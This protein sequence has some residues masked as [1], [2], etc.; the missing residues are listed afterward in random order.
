MKVST[1][2]SPIVKTCRKEW[3]KTDGSWLVALSGGADSTALLLACVLGA[4]PVEAAHCNFNLR[5]EESKRDEQFV[6]DLCERLGVRLHVIG[7]DTRSEAKPGESLEM[8]CRRLRYDFF[9]RLNGEKRF[10]R[11]A[12]AH[13]ADDNIET[14]FLNALRGSASR[15]L[16]AMLTDTG[17]LIR[18]LL[19]FH[20]TELLE[21]LDLNNQDFIVDSSNLT[22]D[23]RRNFLRNEIFP[24]LATR[25]PGF[26]KAVTS[27][28]NY[29]NKDSRIVDYYISAALSE[30]EK[31]LSWE[32]ID[33]FPE[34][35]TLI[36]RFI[37]PYGGSST[38]AEEIAH[39]V[40]NASRTPGKRWSLGRT[41]SARLTR[42]GIQIVE[43]VSDADSEFLNKLS[44]YKWEELSESEI[45]KEEIVTAPLS[46]FFSPYG[47]E[48]YEWRK[49]DRTQRIKSL[50]LQ[51]SQSVWKVLKDAG[52]SAEE[53]DAFPVLTDKKTGEPVWLP[54]VKRS[55]LH[56][57]DFTSSRIYRLS[58]Y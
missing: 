43:N 5:G 2:D 24:M 22:S 32:T 9:E 53:R 17:L 19:A 31:F 33:S 13:N 18:P 47:E 7:F 6:R 51:G 16:K 50:G 56:L 58:T 39:S 57:V 54:G 49:A 15:G 10:S 4:I 35:E 46:V 29:L 41:K 42:T 20:R 52:I 21:F 26:R 27:T 30:N 14:F 48:R 8:T 55:R 1:T 25:W 38:I 28:I 45:S 44:G 11:I 36:F 40:A 12:L 37:E 3:K 34:P 23:F